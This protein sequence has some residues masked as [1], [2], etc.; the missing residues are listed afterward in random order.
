MTQSNYV[1]AQYR[2]DPLAFMIR[3]M[4]LKRFTNEL[5]AEPG[6]L[7]V[8]TGIT[9][10][11]CIDRLQRQD[12]N[13][14]IL[15]LQNRSLGGHLMEVV[16]QVVFNPYWFCWSLTDDELQKHYKKNHSFASAVEFFG[17]SAFSVSPV[18][19]IATGLLNFCALGKYSKTTAAK[20]VVTEA[21]KDIT[22]VSAAEK[23]A[24]RFGASTAVR[25]GA[26][27]SVAFVTIV[28]GCLHAAGTESAKQAEQE[29]HLRGLQKLD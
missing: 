20:A 18:R 21:A 26:G 15:A 22:S 11:R 16:G 25:T 7:A 13:Q 8:L 3:L 14:S 28:L 12:V 2:Q 19:T 24:Q 4:D 27:M 29:L 5:H 9:T 6:S 23:L 17:L 10:Y 1:T